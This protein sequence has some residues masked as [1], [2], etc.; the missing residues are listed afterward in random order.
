MGSVNT[1]QIAQRFQ[2]GIT[3]D[4]QVQR[5]SGEL[6]HLNEIMTMSARMAAT[7]GDLSWKERYDAYQPILQETL[8]EAQSLAPETYE[9]YAE[10]IADA[11]LALTV[12]N[13]RAFA[14]VQ[15]DS[16]QQA[17]SVLF[18]SRYKTQKELYASGMRQWA[19]ALNQK[20]QSNVKRYETGLFWSGIYST[21]SFWVL[22]AAWITVLFMVRR[23]IILRKIAERK[24]QKAKQALEKSHQALQVSQAALLQKATTLEEI[25][26]E[27]QTTEGE[28]ESSNQ[29]L[30]VSKAALEQ[31]ASTLEGILGELQQTQVQMVQSEKMSSLGQLVAGIAHEINNPVNFIYA[32]LEPIREYVEDLLGL[33]SNYQKHY[34][35]PPTELAQTVEAA[36]LTFV[37][38][39]LPKI[40]DSMEVGS[41]RIR[42]IVLSLRNFS[43]SD[44][45]GLKE[46]D[47]HEGL[48]STL[49]ILH[50]QLK[51][52]PDAPMVRIVR[53]Y[54]LLP[55]VECY[56]G[57]LNQVFMNL[58]S[59]SIDA[60]DEDYE[61]LIENGKDR[62]SIQDRGEIT[63]RTGTFTDPSGMEWI[64]VAIADT[65]IGIPEENM[66]RIFDAFF[67]TKPFGKGTGIGLSISH[68]I[69]TQK[70]GGKIL[71]SSTFAE[72]AQFVI[73]LPV[74]QA[75]APV[76]E[77]EYLLQPPVAIHAEN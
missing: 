8:S 59:N 50:H 11:D 51:E 60:L 66:P 7:T 56:P 73:H 52:S 69:V 4:F 30:Q 18:S 64:E 2:Q 13:R 10:Q 47:V 44:E 67:T 17:Q 33:V 45:E 14:F 58:L 34:P 43:R 48:E 65:G 75:G 68:T 31:K 57:Q 62:R 9:D 25:L 1:F 29:A 49:T 37:Q 5:L 36:D 12:M 76:L 35:D 53:D 26:V 61:L 23:Y 74:V 22:T 16:P 55:Q 32:N 77:S 54:S 63:V 19:G 70:H 6:L 15:N 21:V 42:Q 38:S 71:C 72:G 39:D 41:E 3:R 28:L 40:L 20:I 46:V 27:L 24:L